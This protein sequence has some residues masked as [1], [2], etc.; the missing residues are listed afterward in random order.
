MGEKN[1]FN[2]RDNYKKGIIYI[3]IVYKGEK[4]Y[5]ILWSKKIV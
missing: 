5:K 3:I 1:N 4:K 2:N